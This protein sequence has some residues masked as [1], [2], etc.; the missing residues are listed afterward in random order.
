[1]TQQ[2]SAKTLITFFT[3]T[4]LAPYVLVADVFVTGISFH[5]TDTLRV[6]YSL[7]YPLS[8]TRKLLG[9]AYRQVVYLD[10]R[11]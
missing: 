3:V 11:V 6:P 8:S 2:N 4:V 7:S 5:K 9:T 10:R 1:M